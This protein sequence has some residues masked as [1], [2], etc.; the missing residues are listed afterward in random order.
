MF[1]ISFAKCSPLHKPATEVL[2]L[3]GG[4]GGRGSFCPL[5]NIFDPVTLYK[6]APLKHENF[7]GR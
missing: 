5:M 7:Q 4:G 2:R 6:L 1:I 3:L